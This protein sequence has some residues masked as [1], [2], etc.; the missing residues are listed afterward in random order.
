MLSLLALAF[1]TSPQELRLR[2]V[3][4]DGTPP[5]WGGESF[6]IVEARSRQVFYTNRL[7][8]DRDGNATIQTEEVL[9]R[10]SLQARDNPMEL[11]IHRDGP[12][13]RILPQRAQV[14]PG[15]GVIRLPH[16]LPTHQQDLGEVVLGSAPQLIT[17]CLVNQG[18][19]AGYS[20]PINLY[21]EY[22]RP[23]GRTSTKTERRWLGQTLSDKDG[24]FVFRELL[25][26]D[27]SFDALIIET[28]DGERVARQR[29]NPGDLDVRLA[30]PIVGRLVLMF[31]GDV[32]SVQSSVDLHAVED[33]TVYSI[34]IGSRGG[35]RH[36]VV[37][38]N[39]LPIGDYEAF[40]SF[41]PNV[42]RMY[43]HIIPLGVRT[44]RAGETTLL[45]N[46][47]LHLSEELSI[48]HIRLFDEFGDMVEA[49][50][51][52]AEL[53][54]S[55]ES[56]GQKQVLGRIP[57][58]PMRGEYLLF[59]AMIPSQIR[60]GAAWTD[61]VLRVE[62]FRPVV[63]DGPSENQRIVV[64]ESKPRAFQIVGLPTFEP[65]E[66]WTLTAR[67]KGLLPGSE[68]SI[69]ILYD[70][71]PHPL[72][73]V[74]EPGRYELV[75]TRSW[76]GRFALVSEFKGELLVEESESNRAMRILFPLELS[77][78]E[79]RAGTKWRQKFQGCQ[80]IPSRAPSK[81]G[82]P[83]TPLTPSTPPTPP[84]PAPPS[85]GS[86]DGS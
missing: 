76:S 19:V 78:E 50:H 34:P 39:N 57:L 5:Q 63:W 69:K 72:L 29:C 53:I 27:S 36:D 56:H 46:R 47:T 42:S 48:C 82:T 1:F 61:A 7:A 23:F 28:K 84:A 13:H 32:P 85:G 11:W 70:A 52:K 4:E 20:A 73:V 59:A 9:R 49:Q 43:P 16:G 10:V 80:G 77:S 2:V 74:Q 30:F 3:L 83:T 81:V 31:L 25:P 60:T 51:R 71:L 12:P 18:G 15:A 44:I 67:S 38:R 37:E 66:K 45:L 8:R 54:F 79:A 21:S 17:G 33:G 65:D 40:L 58:I 6:S 35:N 14:W 75:W 64:H 68:P 62:G 22:A 55:G 24:N 41:R 86:R 26:P